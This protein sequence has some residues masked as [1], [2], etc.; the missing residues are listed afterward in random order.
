MK[1]IVKRIKWQVIDWE[2]T[3]ANHISNN[4]FVSGIQKE[5]SKH[6]N[7]KKAK[8]TTGKRTDTPPKMIWTVKYLKR[9]STS[10]AIRERDSV[11]KRQRE[12]VTDKETHTERETERQRDRKTR[13]D[14]LLDLMTRYHRFYKAVWM[15][16]E[17]FLSN[18]LK[19]FIPPIIEIIYNHIFLISFPPYKFIFE[20]KGWHFQTSHNSH[21]SC[22]HA[23]TRDVPSHLTA[24]VVPGVN[25]LCRRS[26][27]LLPI[28]ASVA[29]NGVR[30]PRANGL[31]FYTMVTITII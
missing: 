24:V 27:P 28:V 21:C 10:L 29:D 19:I 23:L 7:N 4:G 26:K 12:T 17:V 22:S 13:T 15:W 5:F 20:K 16:N 8:L 25:T 31:L 11:T 3:S 14:S 1:N 6:N 18:I 9:C 2:R 30:K